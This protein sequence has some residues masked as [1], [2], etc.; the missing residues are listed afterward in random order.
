MQ[1]HLNTFQFGGKS[2]RVVVSCG[3]PWFVAKDAAEVLGYS[4][5]DNAVRTHCKKAKNNP[6]E[7]PGLSRNAKLIPESDIYRLVMRSKLE[8]AEEFQDWVVEEVLPTIRKTGV[9]VS[10]QAAA[11]PPAQLAEQVAQAAGLKAPATWTQDLAH[12]IEQ[13]RRNAVGTYELIKEKVLPALQR[14]ET[15][16]ISVLGDMTPKEA[17]QLLNAIARTTRNKQDAQ[18][19]A[20]RLLPGLIPEPKRQD[21]KQLELNFGAEA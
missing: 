19:A 12:K 18:Q 7:T 16:P 20:F 4:D 14:L 5:T 3:Q 6:G 2:I 1:N 8:S 17:I 10:P 21:A 13:A 11:L 15:H 9:Y